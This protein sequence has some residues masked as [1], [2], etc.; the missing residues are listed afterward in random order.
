[1]LEEEPALGGFAD[2]WKNDTGAATFLVRKETEGNEQGGRN[3]FNRQV[4]GACDDLIVADDLQLVGRYGKMRCIEFA[5]GVPSVADEKVVFRVFFDDFTVDITVS[6]FGDYIIN[7]AFFRLE[8]VPHGTGPEF[9]RSLREAGSADRCTGAIGQ[10]FS[11]DFLVAHVDADPFRFE[12][13][14]IVI[15]RCSAI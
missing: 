14:V 6:F 13:Q 15:D 2:A 4:S 7:L 12:V 5:G 9:L 1:M 3:L 11:I 8:V 10:P